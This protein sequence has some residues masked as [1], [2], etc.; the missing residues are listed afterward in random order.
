MTS[1]PTEP[2]GSLE[3]LYEHAPAGLVSL[4]PNGT[5]LKANRTFLTWTG[6]DASLIGSLIIDLLTP[7]GRIFYETR[8]LQALW[9]RRELREVAM[10]V[11]RGDGSELAV[12]VNAVV[13]EG[14]DGDPRLVRL[15]L[16]DATERQDY[17]RDLLASRRVAEASEARVRVLQEAS[18]AFAVATTEAELADALVASA[19]DAFAASAVAVVLVDA[20]G[21]TYLAGGVHP[22]A[23]FAEADRASAE[24]AMIRQSGT[25]TVSNLD[26]VRPLYPA[27]ADAMLDARVEAFSIIVLQDV[28]EPVGALICFFG[29][30]RVFDE[31][32]TALQVALGRQS[33]AVLSRIRLQ[34]ELELLA[35]HDQL[36]GLANRK[37][38][39]ESLLGALGAAL[40]H[41]RSMAL[42][43]VDLDGFK[44]VNDEFGHTAG[45]AVLKWVANQ[46]RAA[47][48]S[49]D[50]VGRFGGDE[51]VII[52]ENAGADE[53]LL[54]A[55]RVLSMINANSHEFPDGVRVG[56][57]IGVA[58]HQPEPGLGAA[59]EAI[60]IAAD[61]AM[62]RSKQSGGGQVTLVQL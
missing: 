8:F 12:L 19:R 21:D 15:A 42:I 62:Y 55:Q 26:E 27:L 13:V 57:S 22:L 59:P 46:L 49:T 2:E 24:M 6:R 14:D 18:N 20:E 3:E 16:F 10:S 51:F 1:L 50:V 28:G 5:I 7:G 53:A 30:R 23:G 37:L 47:V 39:R 32:D 43:F 11:L 52:C 60:F 38:L 44:A 4:S 56:A 29:R 35:M 48:R 31:Q 40:W 36:T 25:L 54:I 45:D 58:L 33:A 9:L 17:E 41:E 61:S 34:N